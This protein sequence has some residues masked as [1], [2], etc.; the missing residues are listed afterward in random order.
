MIQLNLK[1]Q[2]PRYWI[3]NSYLV[4]NI[5]ASNYQQESKLNKKEKEK[6][7]KETTFTWRNI[8]FICKCQK[9][10]IIIIMGHTVTF[11]RG[12]ESIWTKVVHEFSTTNCHQRILKVARFVKPPQPPFHRLMKLEFTKYCYKKG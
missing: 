11:L 10:N 1:L 6:N 9:S 5:D 8:F 7:T 3:L 12:E 2:F 4:L